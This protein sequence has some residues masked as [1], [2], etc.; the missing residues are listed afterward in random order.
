ML[1][2]TS[3]DLQKNGRDRWQEAVKGKFNRKMLECVL[4]FFLS[5]QV[6]YKSLRIGLPDE[7]EDFQLGVNFK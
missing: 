7:I 2:V 6:V 4:K 3:Y 5:T 1:L